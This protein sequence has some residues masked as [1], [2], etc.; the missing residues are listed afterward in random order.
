MPRQLHIGLSLSPTWLRGEAW[1]RPDSHV[2]DLLDIDFQIKLAQQAERAKLDF[3]FKPDSLF[4]DAAGLGTSPGMTSLDPIVMLAAIAQATSHIGLV[5]TASTTFNP[6]Y[7]LARQIQ[8][9]HWLS[10]GRAGWNIVTSLDGERNFGTDTMPSAEWRYERAAEFTDLVRKLWD[11]YPADALVLDRQ[12][13]QFADNS[14]IGPVHHRGA[15]FS[16]DGPMTMPGHP[17]GAPVLFQAG[18]SPT[19]REFAASIA[20]GIFASTPDIETSSE[21]RSDLQHRAI[22]AGRAKDAVK[23]MPGFGFTLA[24][25]RSEARDI[26]HAFQSQQ[27]IERRYR[28]IEDS[29]GVDLRPL[30]H[31]AQIPAG[32]VTTIRPGARSHTHAQLLLRLIRTENPFIK[33]LLER[34]ETSGS[35]HWS[36]IGTPED[37]A[38]AIAEW[39]EAGAMD[40]IIALPGSLSSLDLFYEEVVPALVER[41]LFRQ[42][43]SGATLASHMDIPPQP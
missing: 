9:L 37:A 24:R 3:I 6:P 42:S 4:I 5:A 14:R 34:P 23:I 8:S 29:L 2:E 22:A 30:P 19:G 26:A 36:V 40:G 31:D 27:D 12:T 1:R 16:V 13:G 28:F 41:G 18:A 32:L 21:L 7:I 20:N 15:H 33:D 39:F 25:T 43:Y 10:K 11:S 38:T 35:G 17:A